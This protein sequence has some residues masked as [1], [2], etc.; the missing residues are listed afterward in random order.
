MSIVTDME[1]LSPCCVYIVGVK[2]IDSTCRGEGQ[3]GGCRAGGGV[4]RDT[5][6]QV[7]GLSRED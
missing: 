6:V 2:D 7:E 4:Q 3:V 1:K 5:V